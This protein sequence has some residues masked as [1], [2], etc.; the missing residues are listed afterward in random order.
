MTIQSTEWAMP[1]VTAS[2][3]NTMFYNTHGFYLTDNDLK[4]LAVYAYNGDQTANS[5]SVIGIERNPTGFQFWTDLTVGFPARINF[6]AS[7]NRLDTRYHW[8]RLG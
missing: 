8:R 7:L 6:S 4:L 1:L 2:E 5:G 3:L